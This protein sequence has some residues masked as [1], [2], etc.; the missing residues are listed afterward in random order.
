MRL[1]KT[2]SAQARRK[3]VEPLRGEVASSGLRTRPLATRLYSAASV[4][5]LSWAVKC[6]RTLSSV[7]DWPR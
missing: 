4:I 3:R 1:R 7:R 5:A 2:M 6:S